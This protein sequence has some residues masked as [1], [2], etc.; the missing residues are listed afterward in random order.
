MT[1]FSANKQNPYFDQLFCYGS[2]A[3]LGLAIDITTSVVLAYT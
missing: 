3:E 1:E 2:G